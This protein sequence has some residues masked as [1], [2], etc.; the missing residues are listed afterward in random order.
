MLR[1]TLQQPPRWPGL[2]RAPPDPKCQEIRGERLKSPGRSPARS[3]GKD[4][5]LPPSPRRA[6]AFK[7][8]L[9]ASGPGEPWTD[10]GAACTRRPAPRR[11]S[12]T[13]A[14]DPE[15]GERAA[16]GGCWD[17]PGLGHDVSPPARG[18][19]VPADLGASRV[20]GGSGACVSAPAGQTT[21]FQNPLPL[22]LAGTLT[23]LGKGEPGQ[24]AG[25]R[26]RGL[27]CL[28]AVHPHGGCARPRPTAAPSLVP[29]PRRLAGLTPAGQLG[30]PTLSQDTHFF[31]ATDFTTQRIRSCYSNPPWSTLVSFY[32]KP[33]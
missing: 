9:T 16:L 8:Q 3:Y 21:S 14:A 29:R 26:G 17:R 19:G 20:R 13:W 25:P 30:L 2:P 22:N 12:A 15:R 33:R 18:Q 4:P 31:R 27:S 32:G 24:G 6:N 7:H 5:T 28:W 10:P 11:A 1:H 23:A